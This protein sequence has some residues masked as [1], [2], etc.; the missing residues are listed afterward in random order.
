MAIGKV[1]A[2]ATVD[3]PKADF[4]AVAQLNIDNLVKSA[5]EDEQLKVA[6]KAAEDKAKS[7]REKDLGMFPDMVATGAAGADA[8]GINQG[9]KG[10]KM[11][12]ALKNDWIENKNPESKAK[13]EMLLGHYKNLNNQLT[14][15]QKG[16]TNFG[17]LAGQ[18]KIYSKDKEYT[19]NLLKSSEDGLIQFGFDE[20]ANPKV[21]IYKISEDGKNKE[22][23]KSV[24]YNEY[25]KNIW[26]PVPKIDI[27]ADASATK[28]VYE[29]DFTE[30]YSG[31]T[32][33]G[34]KELSEDAKKKIYEDCLSKVNDNNFAYVA[35][36]IYGVLKKDD[37]RKSGFSDTEK[38]DIA[39]KH[40]DKIIGMFGREVAK[41][42]TFFAPKDGSGDKEPFTPSTIGL[43]N[44]DFYGNTDEQGEQIDNYALNAKSSVL[45]G[46]SGT[47]AKAK[48]FIIPSFHKWSANNPQR[49]PK[50]TKDIMSDFIVSDLIY[51]RA[52]RPIARG[53]Y[54]DTKTKTYKAAVDGLFQEFKRDAE[55]RKSIETDTELYAKAEEALK[56]ELELKSEVRGVTRINHAQAIG[57]VV[58]QNLATY[59]RGKML[60]GVKIK[61][62]P[63]MRK[64]MGYNK[65][66][67]NK[68]SKY[69]PK[70]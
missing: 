64:A 70:K 63:S 42:T 16:A 20:D 10:L 8:S 56:S 60:N 3:A 4:G 66:T 54:V 68:Y 69:N 37:F 11:Y 38:K 34:V 17:T 49:V 18:D 65:T 62:V 12:V 41:D 31:R 47:S 53:S 5:K 28:G 24:D 51:D 61:D 19:M 27:D 22:F 30:K 59:M 1:N 48:K 46:I 6:K 67:E 58:E 13:A 55:E 57:P 36:D 40:A 26:T 32:K 15:L 35:G 52:G 23:V 45:T 7:E 14:E 39:R 2:Y 21:G 33:T 29:K 44:A 25:Y 9:A 50:Q 43:T